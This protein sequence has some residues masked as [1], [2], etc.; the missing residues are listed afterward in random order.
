VNPGLVLITGASDLQ[1]VFSPDVLPG[2]LQ[3]YM[4]GIKAAFIVAIAFCGTACLCS[5]AVPIKKLPTHKNEDAPMV[6]G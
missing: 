5:L 2:V 6:M 1:K 4:V 3:A